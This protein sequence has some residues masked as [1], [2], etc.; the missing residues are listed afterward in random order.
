MTTE[1]TEWEILSKKNKICELDIIPTNLLQDKLPTVLETIT[2][3]VNI[4]L[5]TGTFP[6]DWKKLFLDH[7]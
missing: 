7:Y 3:I 2:Q 1:E 5:M 4:L 6:I